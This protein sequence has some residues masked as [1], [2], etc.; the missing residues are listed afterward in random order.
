MVHQPQLN[1][2]GHGYIDSRLGI[3]TT[4]P[5]QDL[6]VVGQDPKIKIM[7]ER[8]NSGTGTTN[9]FTTLGYDSSGARPFILS[10][11]SNTPILF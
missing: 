9:H 3:G 10:N 6:D 11:Q 2:F 5:D 1:L 7:S 8:H 4:S